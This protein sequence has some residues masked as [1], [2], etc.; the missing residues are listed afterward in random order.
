M[1]TALVVEADDDDEDGG[2]GDMEASVTEASVFVSTA[3][4]GRAAAFG[5]TAVSTGNAGNV[6]DA[7]NAA[8]SSGGEPSND[9]GTYRSR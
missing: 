2:G 5:D 6:N 1:P 7:G 4:D 9:G 8:S 3:G